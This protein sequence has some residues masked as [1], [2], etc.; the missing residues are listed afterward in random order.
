MKH[1]P[2]SRAQALAWAGVIVLIA[3]GATAAS[4]WAQSDAPGLAVETLKPISVSASALTLEQEDMITPATLLREDELILQRE[5]SLGQTLE[6]QPGITSSHFSAGAGR[7][8]IRGMDGPRLKIL[9]DG[10]EVQDASAMSPDHAVVVE[11]LLSERVEILRGPSA[12]A[13][14]GGAVGGVVNVLDRRIPTAIPEKGVAGSAELRGN[15]GARERAGAFELTAGTGN[16]AIHAEGAKRYAGDYRVGDG[17]AGGGKV[18]GSYNRTHSGAIGMSWIGNQGYLGVGFMT[19]QANYGLPGHSHE[20]EDCHPHG[21]HLHCGGHGHDDHDDDHDGDHDHDH[22][23]DHH[24]V[25]YVQLKSQRWDVRGEVREPFAGVSRIR[26]RAGLTDYRHHEIEHEAIATTFRSKGYDG[27]V[28]VEHQPLGGFRGLVGLQLSERDFSALGTE[29]YVDPTL[30]RRQGIFLVE[31][32]RVGDWRFEAGL[33]HERQSVKVENAAMRNRDHSGN[34]ASVGALWKFAPQYSLGASLSRTYRLPSAEE[35][36]A[37]GVHLATNTYEIGNPDLKKETAQNVDLTLSKHAGA[38]TFA[39]SAFH[40]RI[41]NYIHVHTLDRHEDFQ[42]IEYAQRDATFTGIEGKLRQQITPILG[43]TVFGDYV[44]AS[45]DAAAGNRNLPRIPAHRYGVRLDAGWQGISGMLEWFRV[46]SQNRVAEFE[47]TTPGY[48]MLNLGLAYER[49]WNNAD[50]QFYLKANNLTDELA[51]RHASFIKTA[52][53]L[54]GRSLTLG[55][56]V[57]F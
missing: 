44:R 17:W 43:V 34:S 13:Y 52:A 3:S 25:P 21:T 16:F 53:P 33:R 51:Y 26:L 36:Y 39:V 22:D 11:P 49:R 46:G 6:N 29:A 48:N 28:E 1:R 18:E 12:L 38:T 9:S 15:S 14:G 5:A 55:M 42:L 30:T 41:R 7:P 50:Y 10:A 4:A 35:L 24:A 20:Y 40:N 56:R 31:E 37:N 27:R 19:H 54:M 23:H 57:S 47:S 32:Y 45:L 8:I 2:E